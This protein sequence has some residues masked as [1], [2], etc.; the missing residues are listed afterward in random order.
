MKTYSKNLMN[1]LSEM[2]I[3]GSSDEEIQTAKIEWRRKYKREWKSKSK[4]SKELRPGFTPQ[5]FEEI[6]IR[7]KLYGLNPTSYA[8]ELILSAQEHTDL[9]PRKDELLY[10]LQS[11]SMAEISLGKISQNSEARGLLLQAEEL[12]LK[13]LNIK[14]R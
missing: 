3:L 9:I 11:I 13:Y 5:Q 2:G 7:A 10:I 1:Y 14:S 4:K 12:L 8:R 6:G